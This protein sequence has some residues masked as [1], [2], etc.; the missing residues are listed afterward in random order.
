MLSPRPPTPPPLPPPPTTTLATTKPMPSNHLMEHGAGEQLRQSSTMPEIQVSESELLR[1]RSVC[2]SAS[3]RERL[4]NQP[5][6]REYAIRQFNYS[7][8]QLFDCSTIQGSIWQRFRCKC[9]PGTPLVRQWRRFNCINS[10]QLKLCLACAAFSA[11]ASATRL[12]SVSLRKL[13]PLSRCGSRPP[14]LLV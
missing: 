4:G 1:N 3:E 6:E 11:R 10:A 2:E 8:I 9:L 12:R 14:P 13:S 5:T 7:S